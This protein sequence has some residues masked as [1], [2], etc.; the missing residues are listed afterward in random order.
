MQPSRHPSTLTSQKSPTKLYGTIEAPVLLEKA[1]EKCVSIYMHAI[2]AGMCLCM[3]MLY[4][5]IDTHAGSSHVEIVP[6]VP[7]NCVQLQST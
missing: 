1:K 4:S 2:C 7:E 5:V 6:T 3:Y